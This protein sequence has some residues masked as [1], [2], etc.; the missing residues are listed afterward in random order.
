MTKHDRE[1]MMGVPAKDAVHYMLSNLLFSMVEEHANGSLTLPFACGNT[2]VYFRTGALEQLETKRLDYFTSSAVVIQKWI[3]RLQGEALYGKMREASI[4]VQ[5]F[6]RGMVAYQRYQKQRR[7]VVFLESWV[8]GRQATKRV[9]TIRV[10]N[11]ATIIQTKYVYPVASCPNVLLLVRLFVSLCT[12]YPVTIVQCLS[13]HQH[14]SPSHT[15]TTCRRFVLSLSR[16][17]SLSSFGRFRTISKA[18]ELAQ[19]KQAAIVLQRAFR[20]KEKRTTFSAKLAVAVEEARM[21][22]KLLGLKEQVAQTAQIKKKKK[23]AGRPVNEDLLEEIERYV[24]VVRIISC[25]SER[26]GGQ[27]FQ[28]FPFIV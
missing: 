19:F 9:Q 27:C 12:V 5:R 28:W 16:S 13:S 22:N 8:R 18:T 25:A 20:T 2:K 23:S 7:A 17:L 21:D 6:S 1:Y 15:H 14:V 24:P 11:A 4:Q 10:N 26:G 3:R